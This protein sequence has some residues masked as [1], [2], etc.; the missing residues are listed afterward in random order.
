VPEVSFNVV[1]DRS[2]AQAFGWTPEQAVGQSVWHKTLTDGV[3][4]PVQIIGVIEDRPQNLLVLGASG[5]MYALRPTHAGTPLVRLGAGAGADSVAAIDQALARLSPQVEWH[6]NF[7]DDLFREASAIIDTVM[8]AMGGLSLFAVIIAL[9]GLAGM[10]VHTLNSRTEEIG[11]RKILG[12]DHF[13]ILRL[14]LWDL[15]RP[16]LIASVA[17]WPLGYGAARI[18]LSL[19]TTRVSLEP[20]PFLASLALTMGV[21]WLTVGWRIAQASVKSPAEVLRYE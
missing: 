6:H 14:L 10:A 20:W 17:A 12:A 16:V 9:L 5:S 4:A 1:V 7:S 3:S 21:A 15:S 13:V 11:I 2:F 18:Y 19:F 8:A